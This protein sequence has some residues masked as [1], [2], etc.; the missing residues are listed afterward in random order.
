MTTLNGPS[1]SGPQL[2]SLV[3]TKSEVET[4]QVAVPTGMKPV[5]VEPGSNLSRIAADNGMT[6]EQLLAINP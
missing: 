6:L 3:H 2:G 1:Y 4:S 5:V